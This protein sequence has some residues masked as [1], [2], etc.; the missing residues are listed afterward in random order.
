MSIS[1]KSPNKQLNNE[2]ISTD[3]ASLNTQKASIIDELGTPV[4]TF[5]NSLNE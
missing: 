3:G 4:N 1:T 5:I 2:N